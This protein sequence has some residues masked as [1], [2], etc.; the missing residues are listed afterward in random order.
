[1]IA[2]I[3]LLAGAA[4][5]GGR[6]LNQQAQTGNRTAWRSAAARV[7]KSVISARQDPALTVTGLFAERR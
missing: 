4:F 7:A 1:M 6:L 5:V 2:L 3:A